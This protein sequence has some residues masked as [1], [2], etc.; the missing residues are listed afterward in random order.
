[1]N[2]AIDPVGCAMACRTE[3][4]KMLAAC[5]LL[6]A[7]FGCGNSAHQG[8]AVPQFAPSADEPKEGGVLYPGSL[9]VYA[10]FLPDSHA[11]LDYILKIYCVARDSSIQ[12][13]AQGLADRS[14]SSIQDISVRLSHAT[15]HHGAPASERLVMVHLGNF[16]HSTERRSPLILDKVVLA[17]PGR[18]LLRYAV[19]V[20]S[21]G[22]GFLPAFSLDSK[23]EPLMADAKGQYHDVRI[24]IDTRGVEGFMFSSSSHAVEVW[25]DSWCLPYS[26]YLFSD[27]GCGTTKDR[28]GYSVR[29]RGVGLLGIYKAPKLDHLMDVNRFAAFSGGGD[30]SD[31]FDCTLQLVYYRIPGNKV[32]EWMNEKLVEAKPNGLKFRNLSQ[33][34][35]RWPAIRLTLP[36]R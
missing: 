18:P 13:L 25:A 36:E 17:P 26:N 20:E 7:L 34:G 21:R 35:R 30:L 28:R 23:T 32:T 10:T 33:L 2:R 22:A 15:G 1:M 8:S 4:I 14:F 3:L 31:D 19:Y 27:V 29:S 11:P 24:E 16:A 6:L 9:W 5:A 12:M